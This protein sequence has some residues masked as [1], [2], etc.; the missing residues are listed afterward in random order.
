MVDNKINQVH[1]CN[2]ATTKFWTSRDKE[3]LQI[4]QQKVVV[5]VWREVTVIKKI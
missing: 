2:T 3:K 5:D 1:V 4:E